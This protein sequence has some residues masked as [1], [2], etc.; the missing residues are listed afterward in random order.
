M[1]SEFASQIGMKGKYFCP[2]CKAKSDKN[3]RAPGHAG[4][5]DRLR[6][7]MTVSVAQ[8]TRNDSDF[9]QAGEPRS[10]EQTIA[11]LAAQ[12]K[13]AIDGAPSAVDDLATE[14]GSKDKYFQHFVDKLQAAASKLREEQKE[15]GP[16]PSESGL[17]KAEEVKHLLQQL[18]DEMPANIFNP[19]L[20]ILGSFFSST[21][22]QILISTNNRLGRKS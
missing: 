16:G 12:L 9:F 2:V 15:R 3:N 8:F 13:R 1:S 17:S 4:E 18:R 6:D 22:F 7:F 5:I 10:K 11:D 21:L 19:V 14:S 20:S